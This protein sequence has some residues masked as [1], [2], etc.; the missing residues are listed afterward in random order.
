ML[1]QGQDGSLSEV[2]LS[3]IQGKGNY[4]DRHSSLPF[5]FKTD[6][7]ETCIEKI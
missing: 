4:A 2:I 7:I 1:V 6:L 5:L 3:N